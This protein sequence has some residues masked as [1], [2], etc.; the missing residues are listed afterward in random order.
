MIKW[1][2][3]KFSTGSI[4]KPMRIK[5]YILTW[6]IMFMYLH[7]CS[8]CWMLIGRMHSEKWYEGW[9][10]REFEEA[11][12][13]MS[14]EEVH[15]QAILSMNGGTYLNS[16]VNIVDTVSKVGYGMR[17]L[18]PIEHF[19]L[20]LLMFQSYFFYA[21]VETGVSPLKFDKPINVFLREA[22]QDFENFISDLRN[23][24]K[25]A[26]VKLNKKMMSSTMKFVDMQFRYSTKV[27][28]SSPFYH[29]LSPNLKVKLVSTILGKLQ[30]KFC[31]FFNDYC[32]NVHAD[33]VFIRK[34]VTN[35]RVKIF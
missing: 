23:K 24:R 34:I 19:V 28:F 4:H 2:M 33:K 16:W 6:F 3:Q 13:G 31:F 32:K 27:A 15:S 5:N 21:L 29:A 14:I 30:K 25:T 35:M 1:F 20:L 12:P 8:C 17:P 26:N 11:N 18:V 9:I 7:T 10:I 22:T